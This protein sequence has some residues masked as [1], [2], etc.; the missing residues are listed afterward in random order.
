M[1]LV[2]VQKPGRLQPIEGDADDIIEQVAPYERSLSTDHAGF[3]KKMTASIEKM[4]KN[5]ILQKIRGQDGRYEISPTL[6]LLF[7]A[8]EIAALTRQYRSLAAETSLVAA[9]KNDD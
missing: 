5:S 8:E 6:K 4:K 1:R 2:S 3:K 9:D 7:S